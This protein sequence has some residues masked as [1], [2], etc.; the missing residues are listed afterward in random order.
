MLVRRLYASR[1]YTT[2]AANQPLD[3]PDRVALAVWQHD[4][5]VGTLTVGRDSPSGLL[6]DTL[7]AP[8][9]ATLRCPHRVV[10]E[11]TKLAVDPDFSS[12]KLLTALFQ[13]ARKYGKDMFDASDVVI[14]VNPRHLTYYS[15][16]LGFK[17]LGELRYCP[18]V[19][20]PAVLLHHD[21]KNLTFANDKHRGQRGTGISPCIVLVESKVG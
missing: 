9:V 18:R 4:D 6:A 14:E 1:A 12:R 21:L 19:D 20:A 5:V 15:R 13:A 17:P 11:V 3:D 8:E 7:Y 10:C 16:L 2:E